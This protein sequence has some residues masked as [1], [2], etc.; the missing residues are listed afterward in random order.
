MSFSINGNFIQI[1]GQFLRYT[2]DRRIVKNRIAQW[3]SILY[4]R[5]LQ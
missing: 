3:V 5:M 2:N 4:R 1:Y